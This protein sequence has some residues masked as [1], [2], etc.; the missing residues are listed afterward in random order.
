[1]NLKNINCMIKAGDIRIHTVL[2]PPGTYGLVYYSRKY[3]YHIFISEDLSFEA[4]HEILFYKIHHII[5]DMP[6]FTYA[7]GLDM[8]WEKIGR[9]ACYVAREGIK[10]I[11]E[12]KHHEMSALWF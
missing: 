7:I 4:K 1:M 10:N 9:K 8:Q 2:P 3:I 12:E 5:E 11:V 6:K